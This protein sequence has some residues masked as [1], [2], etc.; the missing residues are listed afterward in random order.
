VS[1]DDV[2]LITAGATGTF[3]DASA[4][5]G[6]TVYIS[7]LTLGG[8]TARNY[9]LLQ[10]TTTADITS[11][12]LTVVGIE[13]AS[14]VYDGTTNATLNVTNAVLVGVASGDDVSLD[15]TNAVGAFTDKLVGTA[16]TVNITGLA[17]FG[18][19]TGKYTLTQPTTNADITAA[20]LTVTGVTAGDKLYDG[21]MTATLNTGSAALDGVISGD[22]VTLDASSA[23]GAFADATQARTRR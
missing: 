12:G 20:S 22:D 13:A 1:G 15:T 23:T 6:K 21:N 9:L 16:K 4:G 17:L 18:A 3:A 10:P 8:T 11:G 7:G 14:K 2:T 5:T 19:D